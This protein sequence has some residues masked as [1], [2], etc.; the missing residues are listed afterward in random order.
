MKGILDFLWIVPSTID[1]SMFDYDEWENT[2]TFLDLSQNFR[3]AREI[4]KTTKS[5]AEEK[6]YGY[7][8]GIVMPPEN[9]PT[10]CTPVFVDTLEDAVVEARKR[11]K[12]GILII[13]DEEYNFDKLKLMKENWKVYHGHRN[14]FKKEENPYKFLQDG[15]VLI[16]HDFTSFGF[17]WTTVIVFEGTTASPHCS[18]QDFRKHSLSERKCTEHRARASRRNLLGSH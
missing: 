1:I 2:F 10:G 15:N 18:R 14:D 7:N 4:V 6:E 13:V 5:V 17:E 16:I 3:N 8:E 9:F 11:T 12:D